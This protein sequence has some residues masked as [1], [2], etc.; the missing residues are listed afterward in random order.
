MPLTFYQKPEMIKP[1]REACWKSEI[2]QNLVF[3]HQIISQVVNA[4]K[5]FLKKMKCFSSEHINDKKVKKTYC[6][7]G[8]SI[9]GLNKESD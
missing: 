6:W 2:G 4:K 8:E 5:K 3:L 7:Y 9:S 1:V